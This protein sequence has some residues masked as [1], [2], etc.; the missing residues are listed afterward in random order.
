MKFR[1]KIS[2]FVA[3]AVVL[4]SAV[5]SFADSTV[6]PRTPPYELTANFKKNLP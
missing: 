2:A 6:E 3:S 4:G 5:N 1:K